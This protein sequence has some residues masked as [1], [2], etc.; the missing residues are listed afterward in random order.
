MGPLG[1][2]RTGGITARSGIRPRFCNC[3]VNLALAT[4]SKPRNV[5][6]MM[7]RIEQSEAVAT[8]KLALVTLA[9]VLALILAATT[10]CSNDTVAGT[11]TVQVFLTDA[12]LDLT[13]VN[14]VNVTV[15]ELSLR[16]ADDA[17]GDSEKLTL[18]GGEPW[19][20]NLLDY[21]NGDTVLMATGDIPA[22]EYAKIRFEVSAAELAMD[23]DGDEMTPDVVEPIFNPSGKVD[24]P[25][26][27]LVTAGMDMS[28]TLDFDAELSVQ[29]NTT[30][31]THP[32]IL[33][34]VINVVEMN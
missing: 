4:R 30:G 3:R 19:T 29:V 31:G 17:D 23:D 28:I 21:Q 24:I 8:G 6:G 13:T 27:F 34:P 33:R 14:A 2:P 12:P 16:T 11:A 10:S 25:V 15:T 20:V 7:E 18:V 26:P 1:G 22:G 5:F 32:Y 9:L